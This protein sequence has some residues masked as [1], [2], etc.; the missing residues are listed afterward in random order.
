MSK[1]HGQVSIMECYGMEING[2][3]NTL[4]QNM[5]IMA[6][7]AFSLLNVRKI[8]YTWFRFVE[9]DKTLLEPNGW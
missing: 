2:L 1:C 3:Q 6:Y 7:I 4:H 5:V 9:Y 8:I